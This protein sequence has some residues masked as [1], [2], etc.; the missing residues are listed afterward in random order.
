MAQV[1]ATALRGNGGIWRTGLE[2]MT[3]ALLPPQHWQHGTSRTPSSGLTEDWE[4]GLLKEYSK[5]NCLS[6]DRPWCWQCGR[7]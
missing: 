7:P 5:R 1:P 6:I 4:S 2:R 3:K